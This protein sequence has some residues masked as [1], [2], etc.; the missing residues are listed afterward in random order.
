M[1]PATRK[2]TQNAAKPNFTRELSERSLKSCTSGRIGRFWKWPPPLTTTKNTLPRLWNLDV[3][4][5]MD[6]IKH[7]VWVSGGAGFSLLSESSDTSG[8]DR[9]LQWFFDN[10]ESS[11]KKFEKHH[12]IEEKTIFL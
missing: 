1:W 5:H 3:R 8:F 2:G 7:E 9:T 12:S 6:T 10:N 11:K 4:A